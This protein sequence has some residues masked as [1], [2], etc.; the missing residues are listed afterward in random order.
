MSPLRY[1]PR[2]LA[3][4]FGAITFLAVASFLYFGLTTPPVISYT[5]LGDKPVAQEVIFSIPCGGAGPHLYMDRDGQLDPIIIRVAEGLENPEESKYAVSANRFM[6]EGYL[7]AR[8]QD[9]KTMPGLYM[10][11]ISWEP[12][13]PYRFWWQSGE[14]T[15]LEISSEPVRFSAAGQA[16][17][18]KPELSSTSGA[19]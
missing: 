8:V 17:A 11:L 15:A 3:S 16:L 10:D 5:R 9:G 2:S 12:V 1:L 19:C 7:T 18:F 6:L 13:T 14:E 4:L